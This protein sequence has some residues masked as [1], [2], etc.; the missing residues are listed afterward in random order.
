MTG[1]FLVFVVEDDNHLRK[2]IMDYLIENFPD[3]KIR[4]FMTGE[5]AL[6]ELNEQPHLILLDYYLNSQ[7]KEALDGI[8]ILTKIRERNK[9]IRVVI[10]SG[11]EDPEIAA[12][13]MKMGAYDYIVKNPLS[14]EKVGDII[15]HLKKHFVVDAPAFNKKL[16]IIVS[17]GIILLA[18][19][20]LF[21]H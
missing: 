14:F 2:M 8:S 7:N 19:L 20:F 5:D 1:K 10:F 18:L 3:V 21:K 11:Q 15:G 6:K 13:A 17:I 9:S 12:T 16:L 4:S